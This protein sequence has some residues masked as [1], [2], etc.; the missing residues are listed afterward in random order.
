MAVSSPEPSRTENERWIK[1]I[2]ALRKC[3]YVYLGRTVGTTPLSS[4]K[5]VGRYIG[6]R[7]WSDFTGEPAPS[8]ET[9]GWQDYAD[10]DADDGAM[11]RRRARA[12]DAKRA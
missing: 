11:L 6:M 5:L 8:W 2:T 4:Q 1:A 3:E 10:D 9:G 12:A 7:Y